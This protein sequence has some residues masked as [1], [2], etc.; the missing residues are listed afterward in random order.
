MQHCCDIVSNSSNIVPTLQRCIALKIVVAN[1]PPC[2]I[3]LT[4]T[5]LRRCMGG[6]GGGRGASSKPAL[7]CAHLF[8]SACYAGYLWTY[9]RG[10]T[11]WR[12]SCLTSL[13]PSFQQSLWICA[14]CSLSK[15]KENKMCKDLSARVAGAKKGR[16]GWKAQNS[17]PPFPSPFDTCHAG[18]VYLDKRT[19]NTSWQNS[20]WFPS[21]AG[22]AKKKRRLRN[23]PKSLMHG[24]SCCFAV[25]FAVA[26]VLAK[27]L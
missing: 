15:V 11:S 6:G 21:R 24:R 16:G 9:R 26:V 18:W 20:G 27:A 7:S 13:R 23:V 14:Y 3:T 4:K 19:Q 2:N 5:L 22:M 10:L 17:N 8:P 1:R 25:Y 12:V